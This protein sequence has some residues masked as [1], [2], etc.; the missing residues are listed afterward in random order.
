M[1]NFQNTQ[2][3]YSGIGIFIIFFHVK[4]IYLEREKWE[5]TDW[6]NKSTTCLWQASVGSDGRFLSVLMGL[7]LVPFVFS[8]F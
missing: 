1:Q 5:A 4:R 6:D 7:Q 8:R 3:Y 2:R